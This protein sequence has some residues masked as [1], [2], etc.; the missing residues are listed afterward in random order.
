MRVSRGENAMKNISLT[1]AK[2]N[3][4]DLLD[5]IEQGEA[6]TITPDMSPLSDSTTETDRLEQGRQAMRELRELRKKSGKATAEEILA[7]RDEGRRF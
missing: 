5:T 1:E 4:S 2:A 6:V 3:M 7:W